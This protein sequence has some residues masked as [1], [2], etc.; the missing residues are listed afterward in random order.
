MRRQQDIKKNETENISD[1]FRSSKSSLND[2]K[3]VGSN[4]R[5]E[6]NANSN[7]KDLA[8]DYQ[9]QRLI[10]LFD[11]MDAE[12]FHD[13]DKAPYTTITESGVRLTFSLSWS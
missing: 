4:E 3:N 11:V 7:S 2:S 10:S 13:K 12:F 5:T 1:D 6:T 8:H 9:K